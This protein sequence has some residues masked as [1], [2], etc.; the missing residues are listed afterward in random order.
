DTL[1][2]ALDSVVLDASGSAS[3]PGFS[4]EW[5][6]D[7]GHFVSGQ[8]TLMP[9]VDSAGIYFLTI[10]NQNNGCAATEM[11][12]II[13]NQTPPVAD[14]GAPAVLT[15]SEMTAYL[16][17][18]GSSSGSA[19]SFEWTTPDGHIASG[20]DSLVAGVDKAGIYIFT[21]TNTT[22]GCAAS[23]TVAVTLDADVPVADAGPDAQTTCLVSEVT[24]QAGNSSQDSTLVYFW[25]TP[26][27]HIVSGENSLMPVVDTAGVYVL[28]VTDTLNQCQATDTVWVV[29]NKT[30]PLAN[31]GVAGVFPCRPDTLKLDGTLSEQDARLVYAWTTA[32]GHIVAGADSIV[33]FADA[34]GTYL[35]TVTDTL[36][37][38]FSTAET[39]LL[40]ASAPTLSLVE[41]STPDCAGGMNGAIVVAGAG[42]L[43]DYM[44]AWSNGGSSPTQTDLAAGTYAVTLTDANDCR[45]TLEIA[46]DEPAALA[47]TLT[48]TAETASGA[49]DGTVTATPAGG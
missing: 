6:T 35:L 7:G 24:L 20:M 44:F 27:G 47:L 10:T 16:D 4:F 15:C 49:G 3:G 12:E 46:L 45:D 48:A 41:T 32:D 34:P 39:Q 40:P 21:I 11:T 31:A 42:G 2:C 18:G 22:T 30:A 29:E 38:C 8:N 23:D 5:T 17:A 37:G 1:T 43:P 9:V 19:F 26:N 28:V 13:A 14:A 25:T 36:N 33:A